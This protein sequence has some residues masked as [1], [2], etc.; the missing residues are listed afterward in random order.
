M[1]NARQYDEAIAF[2]RRSIDLNPDYSG[3][4]F[5]LADS[6]RFKGMY[7]EALVEFQRH[8]R[9]GGREQPGILGSIYVRLGRHAEA[10]AIRRDLE[11]RSS[12][13]NVWRDLAILYVGLGE[14]HLAIQALDSAI[15]THGFTDEPTLAGSP[16]WDDLRGYPRFKELVARIGIP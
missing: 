15:A 12:Q 1:R 6:Y 10:M 16:E 9:L 14:H 3:P 5:A 4:Q 11:A 2:A 13:E 8:E 7:Q